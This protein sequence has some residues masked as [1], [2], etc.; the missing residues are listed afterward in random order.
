MAIET[1]SSRLFP[2]TFLNDMTSV[3]LINQ[4]DERIF[5][6]NI[7]LFNTDDIVTEDINVQ[8]YYIPAGASVTDER[9]FLS[10][11][12]NSSQQKTYNFEDP[13]IILENQGDSIVIHVSKANKVNCQIF[14]YKEITV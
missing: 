1:T 2:P 10:H 6:K 8:I 14:G 9:L 3:V 11:R 12:I 4:L 5:I 13:G 7:Y